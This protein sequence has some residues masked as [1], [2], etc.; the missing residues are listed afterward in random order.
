M[1]GLFCALAV[2]IASAPARA[3][4]RPLAEA[5]TVEQPA[6]L[7][8][9]ALVR[10]VSTWRKDDRVDA[11]LRIEI[12]ES[13][14]RGAR[15]VLKRDGEVIGERAIEAAGASC[16][17]LREALSLTLAV[18]IDALPPAPAHT[19]SPAVEGTREPP[20]A[21]TLHVPSGFGGARVAKETPP[22]PFFALEMS[23]EGGVAVDVVPAPV[24]AMSATIGLRIGRRAAPL[25][26]LV[27]GGLLLTSTGSFT[28]GSGTVEARLAAGRLDGCLRFQP[29]RFA[30][31]G[32]IGAA[33]GRLGA[34]G[35]GFDRDAEAAAPWVS[36]TGRL[37]GRF[38]ILPALALTAG[39]EGLVP[40]VAP[41][42]E[43]ESLMHDTVTSVSVPP[44]GL[45]A[46][47]GAVFIFP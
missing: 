31:D 28:V 41:H 15:F 42:L 12:V 1:G 16:E 47:G 36:M 33:A 4:T 24:G 21:R 37:A 14:P 10:A 45:G 29:G 35:A 27:R 30:L 7:T 44:I 25:V 23:I 8:A 26:G 20:P 40:I 6:C 9:D 46:F 3:E 17:E 43:V 32:C 11:R 39:L 18:S 5:V 34:R 19:P 22:G 13:A 2:T 38:S